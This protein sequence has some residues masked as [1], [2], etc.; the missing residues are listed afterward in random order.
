M[1]Q[2]AKIIYKLLSDDVTVS[3]KIGNNIFPNQAPPGSKPP[4]ILY[5]VNNNNPQDSKLS[6]STMDV[7]EVQITVLHNSYADLIETSNA[8]RQQLD[9]KKNYTFED[10]TAQLIYFIEEN[11]TFDNDLDQGGTHIKN[12]LFG[13]RMEQPISS[14]DTIMVFDTRIQ[15]AQSSATNNL[16]LYF[17]GSTT[18]CVVDW[19]DGTTQTIIGAGERNHQ[20]TTPGIYK[21]TFSGTR[22]SL[23]FDASIS[24]TSAGRRDAFKLLE[25]KN[26]GIFVFNTNSLFEGCKNMIITATD[27][28]TITT[29]S[30]T[31][32]FSWCFNMTAPS[33]MNDWD[34]SSV[35]SFQTCFYFC[36][37]FDTYINDW[38]V[39]NGTNFQS[40]FNQ[41]TI[42]NQDLNKW[43]VSKGRNFNYM[44]YNANSFDGDITTWQFHT[45]QS[46][47]MLYMLSAKGFNRDISNWN[48]ERVTT[49]KQLLYNSHQFNQNLNSWDLSNCTSVYRMLFGLDFYDQPMN[50]WDVSNITD[51]RDFMKNNDGYST[52]NYDA[53]LIS[54][55]AQDVS[56]NESINFGSSQYTAGGAAEAAR[57]NL[58][59]NKG[60]TITDG[61]AA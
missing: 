10:Q 59:T 19:G 36:A 53:L 26:W 14:N 12:F 44:F 48:T 3:S 16:K 5:G 2:P 8:I 9:H 52:A 27:I 51:F 15:G 37:K 25:I 38:D 41:A 58:I 23:K 29:T 30:F 40:V 22:L 57:T 31:S 54:W 21:V 47:S 11:E 42:Y 6:R 7:Y 24:G 17:D 34:V 56:L 55:S 43:D 32:M 4:M 61:G 28:P 35:V 45:T 39:S 50:N 20:Y 18:D 1:N 13:I 49:M 33:T 60:W 46:V